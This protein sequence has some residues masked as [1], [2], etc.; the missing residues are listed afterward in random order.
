MT[1]SFSTK[2]HK[3]TVKFRYFQLGLNSMS[4][5]II[6][7]VFCSLFNTLGPCNLEKL[8]FTVFNVVLIAVLFLY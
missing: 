7:R 8:Q 1:G 5:F 2:A 3:T 4:D 6:N